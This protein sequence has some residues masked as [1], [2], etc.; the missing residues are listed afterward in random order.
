VS[1]LRKS[2]ENNGLVMPHNTKI[3]AIF[4]DIKAGDCS[5]PV[6]IHIFNFFLQISKIVTKSTREET[7][8]KAPA[9][10]FILPV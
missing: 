1:A 4:V 6:H 2:S 10:F 3:Y 9:L 5:V 8:N 7:G